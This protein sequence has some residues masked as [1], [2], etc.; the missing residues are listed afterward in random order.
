MKTFA[1]LWHR[2]ITPI[3]QQPYQSDEVLKMLLENHNQPARKAFNEVHLNRMTHALF[4]E[5]EKETLLNLQAIRLL[6]CIGFHRS[7]YTATMPHYAFQ[8]SQSIAF[9]IDTLTPRIKPL[10][11]PLILHVT[12]A[13]SCAG[14]NQQMPD[15]AAIESFLEADLTLFSEKPEIY[16]DFILNLEAELVDVG[17]HSSKVFLMARYRLLTQLHAKNKVGELFTLP[18]FRHHQAQATQNVSAEL[19]QISQRLGSA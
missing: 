9:A 14:L 16:Q 7:K 4:L 5:Q 8:C 18:E 15:N 12:Q 10:F 13:L 6:L 1:Q 2:H 11:A 3:M 17:Q 19:V